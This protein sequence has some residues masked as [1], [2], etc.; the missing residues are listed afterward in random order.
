MD[1]ILRLSDLLR[2]LAII[3]GIAI[4][5]V[6]LGEFKHQQKIS[7]WIGEETFEARLVERLDGFIPTPGE[8]LRRDYRLLCA[9]ALAKNI[10]VRPVIELSKQEDSLRQSITQAERLVNFYST[11]ATIILSAPDDSTRERMTGRWQGATAQVWDRLYPVMEYS[12][13][14]ANSSKRPDEYWAGMKQLA[15]E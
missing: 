13:K 11:L 8:I 4:A 12:L 14:K 2:N 3:A 5:V 1:K 9:Q 10:H 15:G 7:S 6:Q